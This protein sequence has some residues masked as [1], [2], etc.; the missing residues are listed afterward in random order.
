MSLLLMLFCFIFL[1]IIIYRMYKLH[2]QEFL[3]VK[4]NLFIE[5][6]FFFAIIIL[7]FYVNFEIYKQGYEKI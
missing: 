5:V 6:L 3:R 1:C 4:T 2:R 7:G